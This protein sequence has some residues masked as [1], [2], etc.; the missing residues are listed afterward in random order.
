MSDR[1]HPDRV[2][3]IASGL[4]A[5]FALAVSTYN[6][7]LQRQ[8]IRAQVWPH[9]SW[10]YSQGER[11][12]VQVSNEGVGPAIVKSVQLSV[13][14]RPVPD[15][16]TALERLAL[17]VQQVGYSTLNHGVIPPGQKVTMLAVPND[18]MADKLADSFGGR[19]V[20]EVCYCSVLN[21]CWDLEGP[22]ARCPTPTVPFKQ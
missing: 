3:A 2:T 10:T 11:F 15:W 18:A 6:V 21:E 13:D 22:R 16:K 14:N 12:T 9:L 5:L 7:V 19:L 1:K 4:V 8:Q 17:P 20:L